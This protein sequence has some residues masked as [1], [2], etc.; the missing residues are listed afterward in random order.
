MNII[1][2]Q[3]HAINKIALKAAACLTGPVLLFACGLPFSPY[4]AK[5]QVVDF[6]GLEDNKYT[7]RFENVTENNPDYFLGYEFYYKLYLS[8]ND[9][10]SEIDSLVNRD[11]FSLSHLSG[12]GFKRVYRA[13]GS[14]QNRQPNLSLTSLEKSSE[15]T[16]T[17]DLNQSFS[18]N[19]LVN[20]VMR[21]SF[22]NKNNDYARY[23]QTMVSGSSIETEKGFWLGDF[24]AFD[25]DVPANFN[26]P[27]TPLTNRQ[28]FLSL[29]VLSYGR[30]INFENLFSEPAHLG[31]FKIV[32]QAR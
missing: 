19:S 29:F 4:L 17:V 14:E 25:S 32:Y 20:R 11:D 15:M 27:D 1:T 10:E 21:A 22:Q 31:N 9:L 28:I 3:Y 5:P 23:A 7:A 26:N 2:A 24:E 13:T 16:I 8:E 30:G 18:G 12:S 6:S